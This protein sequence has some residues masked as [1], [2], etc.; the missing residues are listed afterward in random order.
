VIERACEAGAGTI[1]AIQA[2]CLP[3]GIG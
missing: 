3:E 1:F 2:W